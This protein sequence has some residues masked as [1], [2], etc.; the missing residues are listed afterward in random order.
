MAVVCYVQG[1][2]W[3]IQTTHGALRRMIRGEKLSDFSQSSSRKRENN[4]TSNGRSLPC[5]SPS[6]PLISS[7]GGG[8]EEAPARVAAKESLAPALCIH[9]VVYMERERSKKTSRYHIGTFLHSM[10][11]PRLWADVGR[12]IRLAERVRTHTNSR[13]HTV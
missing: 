2:L 1:G 12:H 11:T 6:V 13:S 3:Q 10:A 4:Q 5:D 7:P 9:F 8:G